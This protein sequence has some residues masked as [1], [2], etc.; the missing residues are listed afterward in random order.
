MLIFDSHIHLEKYTDE[1][2]QQFCEHPQIVGMTAVSMD[3]S[4]SQRTLQW[5]RAYPSKVIAACGFHPEQ[6]PTDVSALI[7]WIRNH[8]NEIDAIGEIGLPTYLKRISRQQGNDFSDK[9]HFQ[10][11]VSFLE[12]AKELHKPVILHAVHEEATV[13]CD[14][15]EEIDI[16]QAHF[17]WFKSDHATC[18]RMA[19]AG[20]MI[21]VTP[22]IYY[23]PIT[24]K[25]ATWY[26]IEQLM[27]ETDGPWPFEGPFAGQFTQPLMIEKLLIHLAQLRGDPLE[28]LSSQVVE[29]ALRFYRRS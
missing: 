3:L 16:Q 28:K 14:L 9:E 4:S 15:L 18:R 24:A 19:D 26:P 1:E 20:Y 23:H 25:I 10:I 8:E 12:L 17:H 13:V 7:Q 21:S 6:S 2:I 5:K 11:L 22:D 27:V 29:N